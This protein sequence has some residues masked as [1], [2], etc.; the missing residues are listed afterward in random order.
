MSCHRSLVSHPRPVSHPAPPA[1]RRALLT[2]LLALTVLAVVAGVWG[3]QPSGLGP[4]PVP[5]PVPAGW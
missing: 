1:V 2:L 5:S 4:H 3:G